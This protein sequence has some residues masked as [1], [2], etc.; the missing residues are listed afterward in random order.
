[1]TGETSAMSALEDRASAAN[2]AVRD[3]AGYAD[4]SEQGWLR[5]A[6][7]DRLDLLQRLTTNDFRG[8][9]PPRGLPTVFANPMGRV[10]AFVIAHAGDDAVWLRTMPGQA[11]TLAG[12]LNRMIFWQDEVQVTDLTA[13]TAQ[14]SLFGERWQKTL[15]G[16][17]A[18]SAAEML[19]YDALTLTF[20]P[21]S[22]LL[23]R[24]GPL[25]TPN[26][27]LTM[28]RKDADAVREML[29]QTGAPLTG[30]EVELL[31]IEKGLPLWGRELSDEVTPLETNLLPAISFNKGC[32]TGQEV[33]ARQTNYDKITRRMVGLMLPPDAPADLTGS[34]IRGPGRRG[35]V[36]SSAYS[37]LRDRILALAI[38]PRDLAEPGAG[39]SIA[40]GDRD[41]SATVAALPFA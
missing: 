40:L 18:S 23:A 31:R 28:E 36:T 41:L 13:E 32:Y 9:T 37:P 22:V 33:I 10:I 39:V 19:P 27:T 30:A 8:L 34:A 6:G 20:G 2:V 26:W 38:V 5:L 14:F 17:G 35:R 25:E 16:L 29:A 1:M 12:Y 11:S 4:S 15:S 7:R 3:I 24:G 21:A